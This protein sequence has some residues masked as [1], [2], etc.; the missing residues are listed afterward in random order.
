MKN[1]PIVPSHYAKSIQP[2][3]AIDSWELDFNLGN[4]IKYVARHKDKG[5]P[6]ED[7]MKA[8]YYL[9]RAISKLD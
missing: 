9:N 8:L 7:L 3:D 6:R 1:N 4:V 5:K 2:I